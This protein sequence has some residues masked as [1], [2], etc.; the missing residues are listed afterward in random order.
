MTNEIAAT[1]PGSTASDAG[2]FALAANAELALAGRGALPAEDW[3]DLQD[4]GFTPQ[5]AARFQMAC[6][7]ALD[8][9]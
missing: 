7:P 9:R 3:V 8:A 2:A 1:A 6:T 5:E 4:E